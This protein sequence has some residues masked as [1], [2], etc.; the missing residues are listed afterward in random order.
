MELH[1]MSKDTQDTLYVA[2]I[3]VHGLFRAHDLELGRDPDT[4]GQTKYVVELARAL[5]ARPDVDRVDL[6]TRRIIDPAV[7]E[8]YARP[9]E[10]LG[11]NARIVRID[12]GPE[13]YI[14][15]EELWDH[16]DA[17]ADNILNYLRE[18]DR[19]PDIVHS[20]YADAG[21]VGARIARQL[22]V[23]L[24][25]TGHSLGRVK[26]MRLLASGLKLNEIETRYHMT[27]RIEA[28]EDTLATANLV[29]ASTRN[30]VEEQYWLYDHYR[31]DR[32]NVVPPGTD[33]TRF[34]PPLG[35]EDETPVAD[36]I[37]RFLRD[38]DK[39]MIL[40]VSRADERK[41]VSALVQA[42]GESPKLQEM[43]NLVIAVGSRNDIRD[44][45][46]EARNVWS[47]LL[48]LIDLYD[49][50]GRVAYP[51]RLGSEE[52]PLIYRL[53][54]LRE[55]VFV[56]PALTEPFGL[57]LIEAAASGVPIVATEDGGPMDIIGNCQ[58]GVL[59]D[60]LDTAAITDALLT[61]L[62][63]KNK[64]HELGGNG[65][66]GVLT[67]YSWE[68]HAEDYL[69][70][71]R[72]VL[73]AQDKPMEAELPRQHPLLF[74]DRALIVD[75]D[76]ALS[77]DQEGLG[78]F[79]EVLRKKRRHVGF[80]IATV[81]GI[82]RARMALKRYC[83]PTPDVLISA[84]GTELYYAPQFFSDAAWDEHI[85]HQWHPRA[86]RRILRKVPGLSPCPRSEQRNFKLRYTID[87]NK[88]PDLED[89]T[90]ILRQEGEPVALF[91]S[92][93][94]RLEVVPARASKGLALRYFAD[95]WGI[96]LEKILVAGASASDE[97]MIRGNTLGSVMANPHAESLSHLA[98]V[99]GIYFSS[100]QYAWGI[101]E[102][103]EHYDFFGACC[104]PGGK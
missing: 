14:R 48:V 102:A 15:K 23:P 36:E 66:K 90:R 40:A 72:K 54:S 51:K 58:N 35:G 88:A 30:E 11:E 93:P 99:E 31:P 59:I 10:S 32:M 49:L 79:L 68:A 8:D 61:I 20:H 22:G 91:H 25:H 12:A 100:A 71:I 82:R 63:D 33:L 21:Y 6:F 86:L 73:H 9:E 50:Y 47:Q 98:E 104:V 60:P 4:G 83:I 96:P 34:Y 16:L 45:D 3:S 39:P 38:P 67:H 94:T 95:Q 75:L 64:W 56:N 17:F 103:I 80:G 18:I 5:D 101:L 26:R 74:Q 7:S 28:E 55:G 13:G 53:A 1:K 44:L 57:T 37:A 2:L 19:T 92:D 27:R 46:S 41:N 76:Q 52:V 24:V 42:Y 87:L 29:I 89:I 78:A 77:G 65:L 84:M 43:A 70:K 81:Q 85:D 69:K 97:D 62:G